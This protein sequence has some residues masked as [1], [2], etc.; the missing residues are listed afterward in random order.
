M[1]ERQIYRELSDKIAELNKLDGPVHRLFGYP[2]L[3]QG[4]MNLQNMMWGD[5]GRIYFW[6]REQD[7]KN[8]D[9]DKTWLILQCS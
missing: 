2:D 5:V 9:F 1:K 8:F 6:I 3:I 4:D 7:L